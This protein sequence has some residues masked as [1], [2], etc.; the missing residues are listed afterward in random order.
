MRQSNRKKLRG[1]EIVVRK[2]QLRATGFRTGRR[3][4][5]DDQIV[6]WRKPQRPDWMRAEQ[7]LTRVQSQLSPPSRLL[8]DLP[9][10]RVLRALLRLQVDQ[11]A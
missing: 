6:C 8:R 4:G 1:D 11:P 9:G 10:R 7:D 2:H 5:Q 3:L